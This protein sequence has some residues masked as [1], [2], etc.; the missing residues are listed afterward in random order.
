[1]KLLILNQNDEAGAYSTFAL[2]LL[3]SCFYVI[4]F[5]MDLKRYTVI[6]LLTDLLLYFYE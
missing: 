1:M 4:F 2:V 6:V 5:L 3:Q